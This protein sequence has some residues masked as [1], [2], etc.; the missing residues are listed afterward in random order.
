MDDL[1]IE[2]APGKEV[3]ARVVWTN[4][5]ECG[6]AFDTN[7]DCEK[8]LRSAARL[9]WSERARSPRLQSSINAR[10]VAEGISTPTTISNVSQ[11]GMLVSHNG[12]FHPGL[13][14]KV[15][16]QNGSEKQAVVRWTK[17]HFAGLYL[18]DSFDV[19]ELGDLAA[20]GRAN[21][22]D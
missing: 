10:L 13:R 2:I 4:G 15:A 11:Q 17:D 21:D 5:D 20:L 3:S 22:D 1:R 18:Y 6:V 14:V 8:E 19:S 9:R 7:I 16:L 12:G